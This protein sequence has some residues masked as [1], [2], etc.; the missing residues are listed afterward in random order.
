MDFFYS[1]FL[2][3][4]APHCTTEM[5]SGETTAVSAGCNDLDCHWELNNVTMAEN[6]RTLHNIRISWSVVAP[7]RNHHWKSDSSDQQIHLMGW[8]IK[9]LY[10]IILSE[11]KEKTDTFQKYFSALN[12]ILITVHPDME[13]N[14][15]CIHH[16]KLGQTYWLE[17]NS[18]DSFIESNWKQS[19]EPVPWINF[20]SSLQS[21]FREICPAVQTSFQSDSSKTY[22]M[23][24]ETNDFCKKQKNKT[25]VLSQ[26]I[27]NLF[28]KDGKCKVRETLHQ[29][30]C[31]HEV[32][33]RLQCQ[34]MCNL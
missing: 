18:K 34:P 3:V 1:A 32:R 33:P 22:V 26:C 7:D 31:N 6:L 11:F 30:E 2:G 19:Q 9:H 27:L 10:V 24:N 25:S 23:I 21:F 16:H 28:N 4:T 12:L 8:K 5:S 15:P 13:S 17:I 20:C 14:W 29:N